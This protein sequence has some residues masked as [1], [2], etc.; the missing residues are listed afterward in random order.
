[1]PRSTGAAFITVSVTSVL[2]MPRK[3]PA[4]ITPPASTALLSVN[5][6]MASR[7]TANAASA[8]RIEDTVPSRACSHGATHTEL[9]ASS[10]PQPKKISPIARAL[11]SSGNGV[12]ASS[13]KKPKL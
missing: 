12:K 1:M 3:N 5:T 11:M 6:A 10:R 7:I 2:L 9:M 8:S 13:V 4:R